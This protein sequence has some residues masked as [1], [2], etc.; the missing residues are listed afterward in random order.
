MADNP[1]QD[2]R[3]GKLA[4]PLG[5][6][7]LCLT[8]FEG[9]EAIGE[10]FEY[11]IEAVSLDPD[12]D[13]HPA[14]GQNCSVHLETTDHVGRD[15]SGILTEAKWVGMRSDL[16]LYRLVLRPWPWIMS[17]R[18]HCRIFANMNVKDIIKDAL[19]ND[20]FGPIVDLMLE[21]YPTLEYTV[22]YRE[23]SLNFAL[24]M[25]EKFGI[26]YYFKFDKGQGDSPSQHFLVLADSTTHETLPA[27]KSI[28]YVPPSAAGPDDTQL[29]NDWSRQQAVIASIFELNDYDY[30]KPN[31][32]LLTHEAFFSPPSHSFVYDYPGGYDDKALGERLTK[33]RLE[34]ERIFEDHCTAGGYAPSLTPGFSIPRK[35]QNGDSQDGE[36][37]ILRC[38]HW[39]G[40]QSYASTGEGS[41]DGSYSGTYELSRISIPYRMPL[42]TRRPV[43]IGSQPAKVISKQNQEID[44]DEYGR[45]LLEF[46][47]DD[48][49]GSSAPKKTPSRRV[50]VG[51]V[52]AGLDR[53][54]MFIPRVGDEVMVEYENGDPDRPI[55]V[56]SVYNGTDE[57]PG[58][59][60]ALNLP[61]RK[62]ISGVLGKSSTAGGSTVENANSWWFDDAKGSETFYVRARKDLFFRAYNNQN[63][64]ISANVTETVGGDE[65]I[66]VGPV[67]DEA[68]KVGGSNAGGN[69]T[70]NAF[71]S[72]TLAVGLK[73][74]PPLTQIKM[75][76]TSITLSVGPGGVLAQIKMDPTGVTISGTPASQLMVQPSGI[77]T[78]TPMVTVGFGPVTF[79]S[80][81][82]TIPIANI[83]V[84][85]VGGILPLV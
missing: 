15:F 45:V 38:N 3:I 47:W 53:G 54:G 61:A 36:Y 77:T 76:Q 81:S 85:T 55:I 7:N 17:L 43:I 44:V 8:R 24:R 4:T 23:T 63:I 13:F 41:A 25:M 19:G 62:T 31:A 21:D 73:D 32:N 48:T 11:R 57:N 35:S 74:A 28:L 80:P 20:T 49:T 66:N 12:L 39:Y 68:A 72:I 10:L 84:G 82:V 56:G 59:F 40:D 78:L 51:Q 75:D 22:Q 79:I 30:D 60:D 46:Y 1:T 33:V 69:F 70:L 27:P 5:K 26:Y 2:G 14:L 71:E 42:R 52:W 9:S 29:F 67:D 16:P 65:T 83:G 6:D 34:A 50:R 18:S 37:L 58:N 64:R